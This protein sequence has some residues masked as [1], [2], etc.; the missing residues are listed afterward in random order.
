MNV[1]TFGHI[2]TNNYSKIETGFYFAFSSLALPAFAIL[3]FS[4]I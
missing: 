3:Y 4:Y 2:F 1:F